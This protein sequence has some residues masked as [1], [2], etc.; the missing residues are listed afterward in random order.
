[1]SDA[2]YGI[3]GH[4]NHTY[5]GVDYDLIAGVQYTGNTISAT[6]EIFPSLQR[7]DNKFP[8]GLVYDYNG[9][10][11]FVG[12]EVQ[13]GSLESIASLFSR[14]DLSKSF[15]IGPQGY[16]EYPS[17]SIR[18][19]CKNIGLSLDQ[20]LLLKIQGLIGLST[21]LGSDV[22]AILGNE[23][24]AKMQYF[25]SVN[26]NNATLINYAKRRAEE[27]CRGKWTTT[28][29]GSN[30]IVC[31]QGNGTKTVNITEIKNKTV[32]VRGASLALEGKMDANSSGLNIFIDGGKLLINQVT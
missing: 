17:N 11:G 5:K 13:S 12:C 24:D 2:P 9:G 16:P 8:L 26:L 6:S 15:S 10:L 20:L 21:D 3:Y 14:N 25:S 23:G 31:W 18:L 28:R 27:L 30:D 32:I 19:E 1:V 29:S 4:I 22:S 7:F